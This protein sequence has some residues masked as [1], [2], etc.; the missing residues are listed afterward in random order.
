M[1]SRGHFRPAEDTSVAGHQ[2]T[3]IHLADT[4]IQSKL[5]MKEN[6]TFCFKILLHPG[7]NLSWCLQ[8]ESNGKRQQ[9]SSVPF[10]IHPGENSSVLL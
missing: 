3:F 1:S 8:E 9:L 6:P 4:F 7:I 10:C 5:L 2:C